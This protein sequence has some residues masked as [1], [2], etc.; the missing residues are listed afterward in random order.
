MCFLKKISALRFHSIFKGKEC[1]H[2]PVS[3]FN[4]ELVINLV[5]SASCFICA[6]TQPRLMQNLSKSHQVI[7][8]VNISYKYH[9]NILDGNYF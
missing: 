5:S 8:S 2:M 3:N 6:F 7:L 1:L 9:I 4:N